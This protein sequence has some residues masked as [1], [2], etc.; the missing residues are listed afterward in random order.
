MHKYLGAELIIPKDPKHNLQDSD[1]RSQVCQ[2]LMRHQV[3]HI[4][5]CQIIDDLLQ[6]ILFAGMK[7]LAG[8]KMNIWVQTWLRVF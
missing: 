1:L 8:Y 6:S 3:G 7:H 4:I 5:S 2:R